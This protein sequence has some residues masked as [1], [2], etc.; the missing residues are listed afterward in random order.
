MMSYRRIIETQ[1]GFS[2]GCT[3]CTRKLCIY[4]Q[5]QCPLLVNSFV[6]TTFINR[7]LESSRKSQNLFAG[8]LKMNQEVAVDRGNKIMGMGLVA[9]EHMVQVRA[10]LF[11]TQAYI[12]D[13]ATAEAFAARRGIEFCRELGFRSI[14]MEGDLL[15]IFRH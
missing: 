8:S 13:P 3:N 5:L 14:I 12:F 4:G 10:S 15:E 11:M 1:E 6:F 9:R 7:I 2:E